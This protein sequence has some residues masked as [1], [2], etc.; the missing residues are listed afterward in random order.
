MQFDRRNIPAIRFSKQAARGIALTVA[1]FASFSAC[2]K[3]DAAP[4][5]DS[6]AISP[7][8]ATPNESGTTTDPALGTVTEYGFGHLRAGM[9]FAAANDT[10]KGALKADAKANLAECDYVKWEGGPA[11]V[12]VMVLEN[13]IARIDVTDSSAV[14]TSTGAK[15]G[16]TEERIQSLYPGRVAV[17][18]HKYSDGHYLTVKS[19]NPA[20]SLNLIIFETEKNKVTRYRAGIMPGVSYIEG[21]S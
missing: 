16:D 20:D 15:I 3:K 4:A 17:T 7:V 13:K 8:A 10:L 18:P 19:A 1:T 21:C 12:L 11:G 5:A 6:A 9:T 2:A 14:A